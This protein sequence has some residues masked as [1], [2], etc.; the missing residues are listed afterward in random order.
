MVVIVAVIIGY[1]CSIGDRS[2]SYWNIN[3]SVQSVESTA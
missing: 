1:G 2:V 3:G